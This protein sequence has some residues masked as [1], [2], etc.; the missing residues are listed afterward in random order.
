MKLESRD[1]QLIMGC[2]DRLHDGTKGT[3]KY[4]ELI[5]EFQKLRDA[6]NHPNNNGSVKIKLITQA[7]EYLDATMAAVQEE[8]RIFQQGYNEYV[9]FGDHASCIYAVDSEDRIAW[10]LGL[11]AAKN[12]V[13]PYSRAKEDF[14]KSTGGTDVTTNKWLTQGSAIYMLKEGTGFVTNGERKGERE[15]VNS[16][17]MAVQLQNEPPGTNYV[18]SAYRA[19]F[20][21]ESIA[22]C[23]NENQINL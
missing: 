10:M 11:N 8:T 2:L 7:P 3:E 16:V 12:G 6:C 23:L 1:L 9:M 18:A 17:Y 20:L 13:T 5:K 19:K 21:A 14:L 4:L 22:K 15:L